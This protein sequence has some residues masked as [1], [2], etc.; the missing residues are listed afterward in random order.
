MTDLRFNRNPLEFAGAIEQPSFDEIRTTPQL[1]NAS[2]DDAL[3]YGGDLTRSALSQMDIRGD[4]KHIVVD[5]KVHMLMAGMF[6]AIPGWHTDGVP[7]GNSGDP[8]AKDKPNIWLQEKGR[9]PKFHLLVTG[10]GALTDFCVIPNLEINVPDY[11]TS[12]LYKIISDE[13]TCVEEEWMPEFNGGLESPVLTAP[14]CQVVEWDWWTLHTARASKKFEW[15]FL[16]RVT[17]TDYQ[18]PESDLRKVLRTQSQVYVP[19]DKF[20]W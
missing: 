16:I 2:I 4:H 19:T 7:R 11:P 14:T 18:V 3:M 13:V 5:T 17:E 1:W 20:G 6:P 12:D 15:R 10:E 9:S 8:Q